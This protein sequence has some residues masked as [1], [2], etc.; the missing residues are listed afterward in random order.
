MISVSVCMTVFGYSKYLHHQVESIMLQS[1]SID[2]LI[3][4]EDYSGENSPQDYFEAICKKFNIKLFY[5]SL[6]NNVGPAEAFR[7]SI[8]ASSGDVIYFS[9]HDDIWLKD[10]VK[11]TLSHHN[12]S[13]LVLVNA[14]YFYSN[15]QVGSSQVYNFPSTSF[16]KSIVKNIKLN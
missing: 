16:L 4:V 9:D 8:L 10:R 15:S 1:H 13:S 5:I 7:Q 2:E 6:E 11:R 12:E 14:N 3:I